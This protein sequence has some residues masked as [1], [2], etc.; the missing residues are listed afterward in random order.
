MNDTFRLGL[1]QLRSNPNDVDY[2]DYGLDSVRNA[3]AAGAQ[4]VVLPELFR[5]PYFCQAMDPDLF[6]YAEVIPG[7]GT[8]RIGA[9]AKELGVVIVASLFEKVTEGLCYNTTVVF[10]ADGTLL[11]KYRKSHIPDDP[12]YYEKFY[13]TPG[14]T[15]FRV[16]DTKF[17]RV[18]VLICWDQ[19]YPEAARLTTMT[20]AEVLVYPTAIGTIDDEGPEQHALQLD[21][22]RTVQRGHAVANGVFVAAVNRAGIEGELNFWGHT[23]CAGPQGELL[24]E[25]CTDEEELL[26]V[27]CSRSRMAET[28][29]IW[30]FFRDRRTDL[31]GNLTRRWIEKE[32]P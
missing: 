7:P 31:F 27:E 10:D 9:T 28:R 19:W 29:R 3:A 4:I 15:G 5:A 26:V 23:F 11:G 25:A 13:F 18:G 6:D 22:W 2:L 14:D 32:Q 17:A 30:P 12:L 20:G 1:V 16:F 21:A 8:D 24:A